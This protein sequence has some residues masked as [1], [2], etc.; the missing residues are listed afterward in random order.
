MAS[1][2]LFRDMKHHK[3]ERRPDVPQTVTQTIAN[4]VSPFLFD[5]EKVRTRNR[6]LIA[7][8]KQDEDSVNHSLGLV[9]REGGSTNLVSLLAGGGVSQ[10]GC[11]RFTTSALSVNDKGELVLGDKP[12]D[13]EPQICLIKLHY[14]PN[15]DVDWVFDKLWVVINRPD[16]ETRFNSWY[17]QNA[18]MSWTANLP[19]PFANITITISNGTTNAVDPEPGAPNLWGSPHGINSYLHHDAKYEMRSG[20]VSGGHGHQATYDVN[21]IIIEDP[22]AAGSADISA[23]Y[24][25]NDLLRARNGTT[26]REEDVYP[27]IRALQLDGNPVHPENAWYGFGIADIPINLNRPGIYKGAK[28]DQYVARRPVLPTGKQ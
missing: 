17:A 19:P 15:P 26:H 21:G 28:T 10:G 2:A 1:G 23:P 14:V 27:F 25:A 4:A 24:Y 13:L 9:W 8:G 22:I 3:Q 16:T 18:D 20:P 6:S 7:V 5:H 11:F 12:Q